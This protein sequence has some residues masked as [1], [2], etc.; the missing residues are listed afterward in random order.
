[1]EPKYAAL[2]QIVWYTDRHHHV[3]HQKYWELRSVDSL[4]GQQLEQNRE[5][6]VDVDNSQRSAGAENTRRNGKS[7]V[8]REYKVNG[9]EHV[10]VEHRMVIRALQREVAPLES[11]YILRRAHRRWTET[12]V[13]GLEYRRLHS[14]ADG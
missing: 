2:V 1:M 10:R 4:C 14:E 12:K 9:R 13:C 6:G 11:V 7:L 5:Y 8:C 3:V